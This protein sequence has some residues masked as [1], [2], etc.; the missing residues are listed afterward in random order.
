MDSRFWARNAGDASLSL[1][2][3]GMIQQVSGGSST[4]QSIPRLFPDAFGDR[5][6][7]NFFGSTAASTRSLFV[8]WDTG[9]MI[10]FAGTAGTENVY[11]IVD[12][13]ARP[14]TF[15]GQGGSAGFENAVAEAYENM[16][17]EWFQ[18]ALPYYLAGHS[19]GGA[20]AQCLAARLRISPN[21]REVRCFSYG[22]PRPGGEGLQNR[23]RLLENVR[24]FND[25]DPV[26]FM[27]PHGDEAPLLH[28]LM[29]VL[30]S[31]RSNDQVQP[32]GG[33]VFHQ[34]GTWG[35]AEEWPSGETSLD[36]NLPAWCTGRF[37]F[38]AIPHSIP[39]YLRRVE[40]M[41]QTQ[42][43]PM[44]Q[45]PLTQLRERGYDPDPEEQRRERGAADALQEQVI[46]NPQ[47]P[48]IGPN[49]TNTD[50]YIAHKKSGRWTVT[51]AGIIVQVCKGK[52]VAKR[53]ARQWN[54]ARRQMQLQ[55]I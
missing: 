25:N 47:L 40:I 4:V 30:L 12:G 11:N 44:P 39:E 42:N 26:R 15:F 7:F 43:P 14:L 18:D 51:Q 9:K 17:V 5:N 3:L 28:S 55:T 6:T 23:L 35:R 27:P 20:V 19:Y 53:L 49:N 36:L 2:L 24:F 16:G 13:W 8:T 41:Y 33:R 38:A 21:Y 29:T 37:G 48:E 46:R 10:L 32:V 31:S 54:A 1:D 45:P 50:R 34:D 52:R 22:S